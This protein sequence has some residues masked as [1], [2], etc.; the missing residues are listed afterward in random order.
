MR[1][2]ARW[3]AALAAATLVLPAGAARAQTQTDAPESAGHGVTSRVSVASGGAQARGGGPSVI[4]SLAASADG[5]VVAFSS[6]ATNLVPGDANGVFDVFTFE[7]ATGQ[8]TRVSVAT[9]GSEASAPSQDVAISADGKVVAFVSS[10]PDLVAGDT[11]GQK[12]VFIRDR[13]AG[14]TTRVSVATGGA[15]PSA[16][17][18]E[19]VLSA[20]GRWVAFSSP[21]RELAAGDANGVSDVFLHDRLGAI[22]TRVSV[23]SG[24]GD[25]DGPSVAP[26]LSADAAV[27][28]FESKASDLLQG[29]ADGNNLADVFV[30]AGGVITRVNVGAPVPQGGDSGAPSLSPDGR[31]VAYTSAATN[32]APPDPHPGTDVFLFDRTSGTTR[33]VS[34]AGADGAPDGPSHSADVLTAG[35]GVLVAFA[36]DATNLVSADG[37]EA[38]DVFVRDVATDITTRESLDAAGGEAEGA[39]TSPQLSADGGLVTFASNAANLT[40]TPPAPGSSEVYR[41]DRIS[42]ALERTSGP[43]GGGVA[44]GAAGSTS[45]ALS[46]GGNLVAFASQSP[47]LVPGDTNRTADVFL[48]DRYDGTTSRVSI[49]NAG[50]QPDGASGDPAISADGRYVAFASEATN[51]VPGDAN[52]ISDVFLRDTREGRTTRVPVPTTGPSGAACQPAVSGDGTTVAFVVHTGSTGCDGDAAMTDVFVFRQGTSTLLSVAPDGAAADGPSR[53]P[54]LS[55]DGQTV[56]FAS[57]ATNLVPDDSNGVTD[58]FV[59][60][61]GA[62][63]GRPV[64]TR[65]SVGSDGL[66]ADGA[67]TSPSLS[68]DGAHVAFTSE[69]DDLVPGDDNNDAEVFLRDLA[70]EPEGTPRA[71]G[72]T[73]RVGPLPAAGTATEP[74]LSA[75]GLTVAFTY[76]PDVSAAGAPRATAVLRH[77]RLTGAII[78]VSVG[79]AA[80]AG[81]SS[82]FTPAISIDGAVVAFASEAANLVPGDTNGVGDVFVHDRHP[83]AGLGYWLVASDGGVFAFGAPFLGSTG[84]Q[85]LNRP[86][87]S[88]FPSPTGGGYWFVASDGGV[89]NFGDAAFFGSTGDVSL[90]KPIVGMAATPTGNGYWLVASDG[91]IFAFGDATF[92]GST[93]DVKLNKP[94]VGMAVTPTGRGYWLVASDGGI[95]AFGDARFFGSTGDVRLNKP[96]AAMATTATGKGYWMVASDGGIFAFGDA[97]FFGSTGALTLN[98]PIVGMASTPSGLGY[99]LVASDGGIFAFGDARFAGSTGKLRL[100]APIVTLL[101]R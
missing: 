30:A 76:E 24:G 50:E 58:V 32:I 33:R 96:I 100:N 85:K 35:A 86:I 52:G 93:G 12:D 40:V 65:V 97:A 51:L 2:G 27:V 90:N 11:N 34:A 20:D 10:A 95:F 13:Q 60:R 41:R 88:G 1:R 89:F 7:V 75:D 73:T 83:G 81:D 22:T 59:A 48:H 57:N 71:P 72:V 78:P 45:P 74:A 63:G 55:R 101:P 94:I 80:V 6:N 42:G 79:P 21:A 31:Y 17:S 46:A 5:S 49:G 37:N 39:S 91:G 23:D 87:V 14:T 84:A 18:G 15:E 70:P 62:A 38:T 16:G 54:A 28:A 61:L 99:W 64:V 47:D 56:A 43:G 82:S 92:L 25:P 8:M 77:D 19:P 44:D 69:A 68:A 67:S 98:Q 36:S 4:E 26:D 66:Q 9:D 3:L 53:E 29:G